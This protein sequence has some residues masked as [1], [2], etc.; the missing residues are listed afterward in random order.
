M[1]MQASDLMRIKMIRWQKFVRKNLLL[2]L[3]PNVLLNTIIPYFVLRTQNAV[4]LF[5]GAQN[6]ARFLLPMSLLLPFLITLDVLK[7]VK[8]LRDHQSLHFVIH[9]NFEEKKGVFKLAGLHSFYTTTAVGMSLLLIYIS[10]PA[11]FDFGIAFSVASTGILAGLYSIVFLFLSIK[12]IRAVN[13]EDG[14][15]DKDS[16]H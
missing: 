1:N 16:N 10:F 9:K 13:S 4:Y 3:I 5:S 2:Y 8:A 15:Y 11:N 6:L 7:K 14:I 12:K